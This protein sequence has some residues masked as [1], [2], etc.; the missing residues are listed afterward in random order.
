MLVV[1][2]PLPHMARKLAVPPTTVQLE[3]LLGLLPA[4]TSRMKVPLPSLQVKVLRYIVT[5]LPLIIAV[6][7]YRLNNA[8]QAER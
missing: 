2:E 6:Y 4:F 1:E 3:G 7:V 8:C 5:D